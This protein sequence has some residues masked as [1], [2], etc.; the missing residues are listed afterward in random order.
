MDVV[1]VLGHQQLRAVFQA[2]DDETDRPVVTVGFQPAKL[3]GLVVAVDGRQAMNGAGQVMAV[4]VEQRVG[5]A[6]V[7]VLLGVLADFRQAQ[8]RRL[9]AAVVHL[10]VEVG[11]GL[12]L[13]VHRRLPV[14]VAEQRQERTAKQRQEQHADAEAAGTGDL[15]QAHGGHS[16]LPEWS[17]AWALRRRRRSCGA[18]GR[19]A[20]R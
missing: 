3:L 18:G 16:R 11:V 19:C 5:Q 4:G 12:G 15:T 17:A 8:V 1:H 9:L 6:A 13:Q 14:Q 2:V 20:L 7:G 10:A